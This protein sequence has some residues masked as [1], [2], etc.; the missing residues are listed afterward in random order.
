MRSVPGVAAILTRLRAQVAALQL[1]RIVILLEFLTELLKPADFCQNV[2]SDIQTLAANDT[3]RTLLWKEFVTTVASGRVTSVAA[4]AEDGLQASKEVTK[5]T[6]LASG[7][8]FAMWLGKNIAAISDMKAAAQMC[9]KA[10]TLG[11]TG[12]YARV[13]SLLRHLQIHQQRHFFL[14]TLRYLET[15]EDRTSLL[16]GILDGNDILVD[17]MID[18]L[19]DPASSSSATVGVRQAAMSIISGDEVCAQTLLV[20]AGYVHRT[21][22]MF[23][24]T[25]ARSSIHM[26]GVS[27]RLKSTSTR[28]RWLGMLV[29]MA[30]SELV[31]KSGNKMK[32]DD[33]DVRTPEANWYMEL[34][35]EPPPAVVTRSLTRR[36]VQKPQAPIKLVTEIVGPRIT[37][38][39][40]DSEDE[41]ELMSYA[42]P[43]SDH[44]DEDEDPTLVN[45]NRPNAPVYI[46]DLIPGLRDTENYD[47]HYL[48]LTHAAP[49]ILRKAS[50]GK[51]VKNHATELAAILVGLD[52]PFDIE[53]FLDLRQQALIALL[54][55]DPST[56][57]PW[58]ARQ[59]FEGDYSMGQRAAILSVIGLGARE[60]A[61]YANDDK[62]L[63]NSSL[64][65]VKEAPFPSKRLPDRLHRIYS[66]QPLDKVA[67]RLEKGMV[68]PMALHA[69]DKLTGPSVL[70]VRTFSSRME[71]EKKRKKPIS[72]ALAKIVAESFFFPLTGRWWQNVQAYGSTHNVHFQPF[73]LAIFLKTLAVVLQASGRST[74]SLPQMTTELWD[75]VLSV[76]T[77]AL[78][79]IIVLEAVLFALL[80]L[81]E[82]N[83]GR[84]VAEEYSK[85]LV[86]TQ[87]WVEMVFERASGSDEEGERIRML[88]AS[89]L[90]K[91]RDV[92]E[93]FQRLLAGDLVF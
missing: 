30:I 68:Q 27:N 87:E 12:D 15:A 24:F 89:V 76:R 93:K 67:S 52:N 41:D 13:R 70:K 75:L 73:L 65:T 3:Q 4:R 45:R 62:D 42:K 23:L 6:W 18:W 21:Q 34:V 2:Y 40:D 29:G 9:G 10:L 50:F 64:P 19:S 20:S 38:V 39:A 92:V 26:N 74:L 79:D 57:A 28:A 5:S 25:L 85:Q 17:C 48:A 63:T 83:D 77:A 88:A 35:K 55:S 14:A 56:I 80:M 22:P 81:L 82:V 8:Q 71:V 72:N 36:T 66:S 44:E 53:N 61:G 33:E 54:V 69:A 90:L 84:R 7:S 51:E 60:L 46:R 37:E 43:D 78:T 59:V 86:E 47:L 91:T 11:Y 1:P 31:D 58:F 16:K 49:L 32:F